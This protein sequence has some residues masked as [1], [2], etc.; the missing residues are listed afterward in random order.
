MHHWMMSLEECSGLRGPTWVSLGS[1]RERHTDFL[2]T[3][4]AEE[5]NP[6]IWIW[7][8][9]DCRSGLCWGWVLLTPLGKTRLALRCEA[10]QGS[11]TPCVVCLSPDDLSVAKLHRV[12]KQGGNQSDKARS[13]RNLQAKHLSHLKS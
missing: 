12:L 10:V 2:L 5:R 4:E 1:S 13:R 6:V 3:F 7:P 8:R 11:L 9:L